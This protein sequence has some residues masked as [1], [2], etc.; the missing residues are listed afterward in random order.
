MYRKFENLCA[1]KG[2]TPYRVSADTGI[3]TA[4]LSDWKNGKYTPKLE[5]LC[6]IAEYFGVSIEYFIKEETEG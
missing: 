3:A 1:S 6:K 5:K 2:I 4:T